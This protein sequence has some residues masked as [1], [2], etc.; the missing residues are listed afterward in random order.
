MLG[1]K[2]DEIKLSF[3]EKYVNW[4]SFLMSLDLVGIFIFQFPS[5][6]SL[7]GAL[8]NMAAPTGLLHTSSLGAPT[9]HP[10]GMPQQA[11][12]YASAVPP[13]SISYPLY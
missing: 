2:E 10:L 1:P 6:A 4:H 3:S 9:S 7:Q 5:M 13:G 12:S 8:P 11:P